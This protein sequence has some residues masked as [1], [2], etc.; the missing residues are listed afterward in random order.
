[1]ATSCEPSE[2][3]W[4]LSTQQLFQARS[5]MHSSIAHVASTTNGDG[6]EVATREMHLNFILPD[7]QFG[8][9]EMV[10]V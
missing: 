6:G 3:M 7:E 1:M 8:K 2:C 4:P 5:L 10:T 9:H